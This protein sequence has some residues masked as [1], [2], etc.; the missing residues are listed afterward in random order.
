MVKA[1]GP[2]PL[3]YGPEANAPTPTPNGPGAYAPGLRPWGL[4]PRR[5]TSKQKR[6]APTPTPEVTTARE[7][8]SRAARLVLQRV[9]PRSA[10][11]R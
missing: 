10:Y 11:Q 3:G 1:L 4:R 7:P 6:R 2:T 5:R 8:R 9:S